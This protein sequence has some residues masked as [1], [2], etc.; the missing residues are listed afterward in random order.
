MIAELAWKPSYISWVAVTY[1]VDTH[2]ERTR[3]RMEEYGMSSDD[4]VKEMRR[5]IAEYD[6]RGSGQRRSGRRQ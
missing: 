1:P 6:K 5:M 2:G 4:D 3:G